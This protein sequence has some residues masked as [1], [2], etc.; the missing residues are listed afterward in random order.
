MND[1]HLTVR[2]L[3]ARERV[4]PQT[5]H[6]WNARRCGPPFIKMGRFVRYR[7]SDVIAWEE[8]RI[9]A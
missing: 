4:E 2:E 1:R 8:S 7:L 9:A 5:V 3:A 6:K